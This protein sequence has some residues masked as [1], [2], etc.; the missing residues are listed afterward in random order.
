MTRKIQLP[1]LACLMMVCLMAGPQ[2]AELTESE[3]IADF[4]TE[5]IYENEVGS[6]TG[7]RFRHTGSGFVLDFMRIQSVP[8]AF[9]WVN[10]HPVSDQGEPHTLEH[11]LLGKGTKGKY[12]ASLESMRLG[13][14]SAFTQQLRTCYHFNTTAGTDVF[15]ELFE[16][17][18]DAMLHPNFS[19][20]EIRREVMNIGVTEDPM[21][22]KKRLE[23]KGTVYSEM[24]SSFEKPWGDLYLELGR[25]LYG[26][27]HPLS[28]SSGGYPPEIRR[29]IIRDIR[30][31]HASTHHLN[32][33]GAVVAMPNDISL[34]DCLGEFSR[35]LNL[36]EPGAVASGHP[37]D[38]L[39]DLPPAAS[40]LTG[41]LKQVSFPHQNENEPGLMVFA[42]P[43]DL[44][45][46]AKSAYLMDLFLTNLAS[47]QT[48]NLYRKFIDSQTRDMDVGATG[49]WSWRSDEPGNPVY[50]NLNNVNRQS[51]SKEKM[52]EIRSEI[53]GEISRIAALPADSE[54]LA[55]F[56]DRAKNLII[57]Q[58]RDLR[59]FL[60]SPPG[61]GTRGTGS[62]WMSHLNQL[63]REGGFHRSLARNDILDYADTVLD[64]SGNIWSELLRKW[65]L[66]DNVPF[67]VVTLPDP[68][69]LSRSEVDRK[70][71]LDAFLSSLMKMYKT[72]NPDMTIHYYQNEYDTNTE[73]LESNDA[74]I[75]MPQF[76]ENPPLTL[77]DQLD[78]EVRE[79]PGGGDLVVSFF[80]NITGGTAGLALNV[81]AVADENLLYL[82]GLPLFIRDIG[83]RRDGKILT[84]D[85]MSET[86]RKEILRLNAY[87]TA[88]TRTERV[89]LIVSAAGSDADETLS[90]ISWMET[91]LY[92]TN[93]SSDNLPRMRDAVNSGLGRLRNRS[94]GSEESWVDDPADAFYL[95]DNRHYL[96]TNSFLTRVH[97]YQRLKWQLMDVP[98]GPDF[99]QMKSLLLELAELPVTLNLDS[100]QLD[101]LLSQLLVEEGQY[102][103][104]PSV[105]EQL[106]ALKNHI[107]EPADM[108]LKDL[109]QNLAALPASS[110]RSDWSYL[111]RLA[112]KDCELEPETVTAGVQK[113]LDDLLHV[114]TVRGFLICSR[115]EFPGYER[116]L[117]RLVSR[118][119]QNHIVNTAVA[120]PSLIRDNLAR[121]GEETYRIIYA[122]LVNESTRAGV[123]INSA[124]SASFYDYDRE[125][126]LDFLAAR[127]YGGGGAHSM[128][129][130]TWA[131]GL[132]YSNGLR[133]NEYTGRLRYYAERCPDLTQTL[134]FVV[135]ELENAPYDPDLAGYAVAQAFSSV[136]SDDRY[137]S[138]GIAMAADLADGLTPQVVRRFRENIIEL[139][140]EEDLYE[141][142]H[143]RMEE[144]YGKILP[145]LGKTGMLAEQAEYFVIGPETQLAP[146]E[147]Y[148]KSVEGDV[149][150]HRLY[151]R[152]FWIMEDEIKTD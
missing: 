104:L 34:E 90:A 148:L 130:K 30:E 38:K 25:M 112:L 67:G 12:V 128:F 144:T 117:D 137:D 74:T 37:E 33:M 70:K 114:N 91:I 35:I 45:L 2:L 22:G 7:A 151:P 75:E 52:A 105:F 149:T 8:Q 95:Q 27:G 71:R 80:D 129:M 3:K 28:Y 50:I 51:S 24:V 53:Q 125:T 23:E 65:K 14:S 96:A 139:G 56:N 134:Q 41:T 83:V 47:G 98:K 59:D 46:D 100:G 57:Q 54:E 29:M 66:M 142:L 118:F 19:D 116:E 72:D 138:R 136:R 102:Q 87:F 120:H 58:R 97:L 32:N 73:V 44:E 135:D 79:L 121:R 113:V 101:E 126:L 16:A 76:L 85:E 42:W 147:R 55:G 78:Y 77:D 146:Y 106:Q 13:S 15:Y 107:A 84:Y 88:N 1:A 152:D 6:V 103:T 18:L 21:T 93:L 20:E 124:A 145:G 89:E 9:V 5:C 10:T 119:D 49:I 111:C 99:E 43:A 69:F 61:F 11:L 62:G 63:H 17:K 26:Y 131:A 115:N 110:F 109:Q 60:N 64:A 122:G 143:A 39:F 108:I 92:N 94:R 31:F 140:K 141:N 48:S 123:H 150:L 81:Y 36:V 82:A 132:A 127:L 86:L 133:S 4:T 40:G 68:E